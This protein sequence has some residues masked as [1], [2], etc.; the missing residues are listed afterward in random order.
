MPGYSRLEMASAAVSVGK[1]V[2]DMATFTIIRVYEVP[3]DNQQQATD[4]M[5]EALALHVE[6]DYHVKDIIR[7]PGSKPGQ[8]KPV[9]L[10]PPAGWLTLALRQLRGK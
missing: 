2:S 5:M 9:D 10:K 6:R 7:E 8:G 3:A 4:R 1:E